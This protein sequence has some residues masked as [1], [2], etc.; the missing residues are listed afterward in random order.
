MLIFQIVFNNFIL[1]PLEKHKI[2]LC[3]ILWP[4]L[5]SILDQA[6]C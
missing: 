1:S 4:D 3:Y 5:D 6:L 2:M